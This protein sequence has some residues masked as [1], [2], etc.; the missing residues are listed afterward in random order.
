MTAFHDA[1]EQ[2]VADA[3]RT[4]EADPTASV[5]STDWFHDEWLPEA[6]DR[7]RLIQTP[8]LVWTAGFLKR[9]RELPSY[10]AVVEAAKADP[11]VSAHLN[12]LVGTFRRAQ[13]LDLDQMTASLLTRPKLAADR[14][15][16]DDQKGFDSRWD[17]LAR[18]LESDVVEFVEFWPL[19]GVVVDAPP[20]RL[21][22]DLVLDRLTDAEVDRALRAGVLRR[23]FPDSPVTFV[24]EGLRHGLR[25]AY[26]LPKLFGERRPETTRQ[27]EEHFA[28]LASIH[29]DFTQAASVVGPGRFSVAGQIEYRVLEPFGSGLAYIP[30]TEPH[31]RGSGE[32]ELRITGEAANVLIEAWRTVRDPAFRDRNRSLSL[33][34]SRFSTHPLRRDADDQVLDLMIAAEALYLSESAGSKYLGE[35][36]NRL[37]LRAAWWSDPARVDMSRAQVYRLLLSAYDARSAIAHGGTPKGRDLKVRGERVVLADFTTAV[38]QVLR[39][40]ILKAIRH[41]QVH[42]TWGLQWDDLIVE[43]LRGFDKYEE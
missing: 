12:T 23:D 43:Q 2:W 38:E 14:V 31:P 42:A 5:A 33:A 27:N 41:V 19:T 16:L 25:Y 17:T 21:E 1:A 40:A 4:F 26:A 24:P 7:F 6:D 11:V 34:L 8:Q 35:L 22:D 10:A 13:R 39:Q 20:V 30:I 9:T 32:G 28:R 37:A 18:F 15:V 36:R 29:S 3:A